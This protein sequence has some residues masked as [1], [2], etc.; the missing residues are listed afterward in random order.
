MNKKKKR[1]ELKWLIG[2]FM[3]DAEWRQNEKE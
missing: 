1:A 3:N 2:L